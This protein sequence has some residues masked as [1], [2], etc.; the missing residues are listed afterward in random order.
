MH[1]R[2]HRLRHRVLAAVTAP[3]VRATAIN[4]AVHAYSYVRYTFPDKELDPNGI[5]IDKN[6]IYN[7]HRR[8]RGEP[9]SRLDVYRLDDGVPRPSLLYVHGGGFQ[10]LSKATHRT[11]ALRYARAGYVVFLMDYRLAPKDA[12]PAQLHDVFDAVRFVRDRHAEFGGTRSFALAGESA[13]GNLVTAAALLARHADGASEEFGDLSP[14]LGED[15]RAVIPT[16]GLVD[17]E[18]L[19]GA[20]RRPKVIRC[21]IAAAAGAAYSYALGAR[22]GGR[23][24]HENPLAQKVAKYPYL[25]PL[26]WLEGARGSFDGALAKARYGS[27]LPPFF[28]DCG[29]RDPLLSQSRRLAE[30]VRAHGGTA[31]LLVV[32]GAIHGYDA[33]G[34]K[35]QQAT[36]WSAVAAFLAVHHPVASP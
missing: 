29:T 5:R 13:G 11:M 4:A 7:A 27:A 8:E 25:S 33:L 35:A 23:E 9:T 14:L 18:D 22:S 3:S 32:P 26:A 31:E 24:E 12:A 17:L 20:L 28:I 21:A 19:D 30:A 15:L 1:S 2:I 34:T 36:K 10:M 16:Y 6:V